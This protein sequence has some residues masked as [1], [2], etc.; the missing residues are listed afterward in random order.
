MIDPAPVAG[1][2]AGR[3][4]A[5]EGED[6]LGQCLVLRKEERLRTGPGVGQLE[7]VEEGGD[8]RLL[9]VVAGVG[10]GEVEDEIRFETREV[11]ERALV[12]QLVEE[13]VVA[14]RAQRLEE[15]YG[16]TVPDEAASIADLVPDAELED[17]FESGPAREGFSPAA[18]L[19][20]AHA[21]ALVDKIAYWTGIR[22]TL[23]KKLV[24]QMAR[25]ARELDLQVAAGRET[26][27]LIEV[28]VLA[29]TLAMNYLQRGKFEER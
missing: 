5:V 25:R 26:Q 12:V 16:R 2:E 8:V 23:A 19:F 27:Q 20:S 4:D 13:G 29:T 3:P 21:K 10:L 6:L 18:A 17:I 11:Q 1:G 15:F 9:G 24:E 14:V 7:Q 28:T 22:R